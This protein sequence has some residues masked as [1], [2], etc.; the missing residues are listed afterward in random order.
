[1]SNENKKNKHLTLDERIEIQECLSHGMTGKATKKE[2]KKIK[3]L[4]LKK[5]K[6]TFT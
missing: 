6:D 5:S 3:P 2:S 1:M 4:S